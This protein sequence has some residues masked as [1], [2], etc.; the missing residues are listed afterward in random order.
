MPS[1][2]CEHHKLGSYVRRDLLPGYAEVGLTCVH[3]YM[4]NT[5]PRAGGRFGIALAM[6]N[7]RAGKE[8]AKQNAGRRRSRIRG[9][10]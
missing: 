5:S 9:R 8:T 4:V 1:A 6:R 10:A 3:G 7:Q 2:P